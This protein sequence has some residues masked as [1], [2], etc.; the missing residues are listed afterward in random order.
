MGKLKNKNCVITGAASGIGR[1]LAIGLAKEGMNLFMADI[2]M[3]NLEKVKKE[4]EEIGVTVFIGKCDIAK[5]EDFENLA[6]E[7]YSRLGDVDLLI[8]N[9]GIA[10]YGLMESLELAEWKRV[11]DVNLWGI[12]H[13]LKAFLPRMLERGSGHI[14]NTGSGSGVVGIPYH[15]HYV[16][17]KFAVVGISEGLYSELSHRGI[18]VSVICPTQLR[19]NII[20]R[21]TINLAHDFIE[22]ENQRELIK[23]KS[24]EVK[25]LFWEKYTRNTQTVEQAARKYIQ[26]IKKEKLYIFDARIVPFGMFVKAISQGLYKRILRREGEKSLK[27]IEEALS[28]AGI[29]I[30][31]P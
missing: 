9:A 20:D 4:I 18:K 12:I 25:K 1:C 16:A 6:K 14:V 3:A 27:L 15:I 11:L 19:T 17:S 22:D 7:V 29:N 21:T 23:Q 8:N 30:K 10:G 26:G 13:S 2:E 24:A 31:V 5:Y 28:E